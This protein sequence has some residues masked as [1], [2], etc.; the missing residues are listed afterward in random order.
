MLTSYYKL[1]EDY[2][3]L[4][5]VPCEYVDTGFLRDNNPALFSS[6]QFAAHIELEGKNVFAIRH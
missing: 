6:V 1:G 4:P 2:L 5:Y 3:E